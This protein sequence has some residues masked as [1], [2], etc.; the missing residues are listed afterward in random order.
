MSIKGINRIIVAVRDLEE[1]KSSY[2]ELLG[3]VFHDANWTGEPFGIHVAI[4]WNAGLELCAPM[5]GREG[6]CAITP[7]LEQHGEGVM[8]V[9]FDVQD[10]DESLKRAEAAGVQAM[11]S[12]D[13]T[14]AEIDQHLGGLFTRYK[15]YFLNA[16]ERCGYTITLGQLEKKGE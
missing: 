1:A 13:Y 5:P 7:F 12:V 6:D 8:N 15:E 10:A 4:S 3:A 14:Q 9:V 11:A 16:S 2:A